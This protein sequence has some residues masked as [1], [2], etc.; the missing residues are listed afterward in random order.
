MFA[1]SGAVDTPYLRTAVGD[2]YTYGR[3][4]G[5]GQ[6]E[7]PYSAGADVRTFLLDQLGQI[8]SGNEGSFPTPASALLSH[9][10]TTPAL[11]NRTQEIT[12]SP[13]SSD[14]T[15]PVGT[16]PISLN[17]DLVG[18]DGVYAPHSAT[19]N[20]DITP[21]A[22]TWISKAPEFSEEQLRQAV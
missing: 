22:Y 10:W 15:L 21:H 4:I 7:L 2:F 5:L 8:S 3:W 17:L 18:V 1:V 9:S 19:F 14:A 12:V 11:A 16:L 6:I 20:P 13:H